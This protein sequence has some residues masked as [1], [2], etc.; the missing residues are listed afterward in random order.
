[1]SLNAY[2]FLKQFVLIFLLGLAGAIDVNAADICEG[3]SFPLDKVE[4]DRL[5]IANGIPFNKSGETFEN[6]ALNSF[7]PLLF[8]VTPNL[9]RFPSPQRLRLTRFQA[10]K[11]F[12]VVPDGL[13]PII[14][15]TPPAFY[16]DSVFVDSKALKE[17]TIIRLSYSKYQIAGFLDALTRTPAGISS[18]PMSPAI[19]ALVFLTTNNVFIS[20]DVLI[21]AN[22]SNIGV[23]QSIACVRI[24]T[25]GQRRFYMG[26]TN[27]LN[28]IVYLNN[29][30]LPLFNNRGVE[31]TLFFPPD[32]P[33]EEDSL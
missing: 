33:R 16:P 32:I 31:S 12:N 5:V 27:V 18:A 23:F 28:E 1:M 14:S 19:P 6:F 7:R 29:T 24:T 22:G 2:K 20:P 9:V 15:V 13:L 17:F 4:L 26:F 11:A 3:A 8:P 25:L 10:K 21:E 30:V